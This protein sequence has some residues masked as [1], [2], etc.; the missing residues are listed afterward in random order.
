M[1]DPVV[2]TIISSS[3]GVV[4]TLG[5]MWI[6]THQIG[7]RMDRLEHQFDRLE[8]SFSTFKDVINSKLAALDLE[9]ARILDK[10]K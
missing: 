4:T 6:A 1:S 5:G 7:K 10:I 3:A 9:I 8:D 2:A